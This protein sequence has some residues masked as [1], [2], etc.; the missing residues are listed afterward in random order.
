MSCICEE[1]KKRGA[2]EQRPRSTWARAKK[3]EKV[4][5][6]RQAT[7][8]SCCIWNEASQ[9]QRGFGFPQGLAAPKA[10]PINQ[11]W[12]GILH[13][14]NLLHQ[15]QATARCSPPA[16]RD[17]LTG[18]E[19]GMSPIPARSDLVNFL[20]KPMT[21]YAVSSSA[22]AT[23]KKTQQDA[24]RPSFDPRQVKLGFWPRSPPLPPSRK[25]T[26]DLRENSGVFLLFAAHVSSAPLRRLAHDARHRACHLSN[27]R[28]WSST[29]RMYDMCIPCP[30]H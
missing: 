7:R 13:T 9:S 28:I 24:A 19:E 6:S 20:S 8:R 23:K 27:G 17:Q 21:L 4:S 30:P 3:A 2:Y 26:D 16:Q 12:P 22:S 1:E 15:Q 10:L 11:P 18:R 25:Y 29:T 5:S 14:P